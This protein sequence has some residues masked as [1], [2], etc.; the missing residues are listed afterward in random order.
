M[1]RETI[2]CLIDTIS[3]DNPLLDEI[4][5]VAEAKADKSA[6]ISHNSIH[7]DCD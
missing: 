6:T 1:S 7:W 3:E 4:E 2:K 5:A